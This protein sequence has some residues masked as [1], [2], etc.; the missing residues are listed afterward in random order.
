[1]T[2]EKKHESWFSE[3]IK[4]LRKLSGEKIIIK[5]GGKMMDDPEFLS[6]FA[7]DIATLNALGIITIIVHGAGEKLDSMLSS[8][9][10]ESNFLNGYR[11]TNDKTMEV[12]EMVMSGHINGIFVKHLLENKVHAIGISCKDGNLITAKKVRRTMKDEGSNIEKIIDLG[13]IGE[14]DEA[15]VEFLNDLLENYNC[16][17]VISPIAFDKSFHTYSINA[18]VLA[19]YLGEV[20]GAKKIVI[21]SENH[22][23]KTPTG[24]VNGAASVD[25][26]ERMIYTSSIQPEMMIRLKSSIRAIRNGV[27]KVHIVDSEEK[28]S[29]ISELSSELTNGLMIYGQNIDS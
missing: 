14:P 8:L 6:N 12:V 1:M 20:M 10:I 27:L 13:F 11:V 24:F 19:C 25:D 21:M 18:D 15:N 5:C 3:M 2:K 7:S 26:I 9:N 16:V 4:N 28:E 23:I 17:P 29:L 22:S